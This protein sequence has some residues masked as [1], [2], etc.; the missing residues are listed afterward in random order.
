MRAPGAQRRRT[1]AAVVD[2]L[3]DSIGMGSNRDVVGA[4][5]ALNCHRPGDDRLRAVQ[6]PW[7][8]RREDL[9]FQAPV[10]LRL[11]AVVLSLGLAAPVAAGPFEDGEAAYGRGDY[12]TALGLIRPLADQ[13]KPSSQAMLGLMYALGQG[14]KQDYAAALAWYRK[15]ADQGFASAQS[16]LGSMYDQGLGVKQDYAAALTWYRKAADQGFAGAQYNLGLIYA[17]GNG[18]PKD[19]TAAVVWFRKA[20]D[21]GD[22]AAQF[23]LGVMYENGEGVPQGFTAA[24]TWYRQAADRGA[25]DAQ[26]NLG[27]MYVSGKGVPQDY[28]VAYMWLE[29]AAAAGNLGALQDVD[30]VVRRMTP[31]Q[32]AEAQK[33]AHDW[34]PKSNY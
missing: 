1:G 4:M 33:L 21:Q 23:K 34:K 24:V 2:A 5:T 6:N 8:R 22:A 13:G 31:A 27:T 25:A 9:M 30:V 18:V 12:G 11:M 20:A 7:F 29:L 15:S 32:I 3:C 28:V 26:Y 19:S 14:V 10:K 16:D 17:N